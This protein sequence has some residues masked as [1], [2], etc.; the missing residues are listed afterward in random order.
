MACR[1][2]RE[3]ETEEKGSTIQETEMSFFLFDSAALPFQD[4]FLGFELS[5]EHVPECGPPTREQ[6]EYFKTQAAC[7][8]H[9]D[10][11]SLMFCPS[12]SR[13]T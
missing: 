10:T 2:S 1:V 12:L 11:I 3:K 6:T 5:L 7:R 8:A 4:S 13:S 9:A